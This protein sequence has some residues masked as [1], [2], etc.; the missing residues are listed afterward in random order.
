MPPWN[1]ARC[2]DSLAWFS[3][4]PCWRPP[5]PQHR[6][7]TMPATNRIA[8]KMNRNHLLRLRLNPDLPSRLEEVIKKALEKDRDFRYLRLTSVQRQP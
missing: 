6:K 7:Y 8:L 2:D 5:L 1:E 3:S 4:Y